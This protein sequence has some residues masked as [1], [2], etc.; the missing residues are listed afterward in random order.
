[1]AGLRTPPRKWIEE[2]LRALAQGGPEAVRI[3]VL[4]QA[5]GVS[6]GGFYGH[7][8]NREALLTE[9]LDLWEREVTDAIIDQ[10]DSDGGDGRSRL[11]RLFT[12]VAEAG[13]D[14]VLS[15]TTDLAVRDWARRDDAVARRLRRV[16]NQR[17][18]YLRSVYASF[19]PDPEDV[20]VRCMVTFSLHIGT[21]YITAEHDGRSRAEVAALCWE[22]LLR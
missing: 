13:T 1:M 20:E 2:G 10:V 17:M 15:A 6:K 7:F 8:P 22:W 11:R 16:D 3:E 14:S 12:L 18:D 4:A 9:M 19:C 5:L 21:H